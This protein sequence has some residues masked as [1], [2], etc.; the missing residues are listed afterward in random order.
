MVS[1][2]GNESGQQKTE[3]PTPRRLQEARRKGQVAKSQDL[4]GAITLLVLLLIL[5]VNRDWFIISLER[6]FITYLHSFAAHDITAQTVPYFVAQSLLMLFQ[7]LA[8]VTLVALLVVIIINLAQ[9]GFL[10]APTV[11][12]PKME[13]L[14][15]T[16][17]FKRIF[18][19]RGLV[20]F[21]KAFFII[22]VIGALCFWIIHTRIPDLLILSM[23]TP[24]RGLYVVSD[25]ML[26]VLAAAA[27]V[28]LFL[29]LLDLLYQRHAHHKQMMM[30]KQEVKDEY[31]QT[32]GDPHLKAWLRRRQR[33]ISLNNIR[34]EVPRAT[35]V[36]TN[37][38]HVAV[39]LRYVE[40][41][42]EAPKVTAKGAEYL[43]KVIR[44]LAEQHNVP[45][46][47]NREVARFLHQRVDVGQD[48]PVG[49]Y[50]AVA[51]MIAMVYRVKKQRNAG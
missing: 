10:F 23:T 6:V 15:V 36:V 38:T 28:Y 45:I 31:R 19:T 11:L 9:V 20:E 35:V 34:E 32:E 24:G 22:F 43:A 25:L 41:E 46:V 44:E 4:T 16:G 14:S 17:G 48:V 13:R 33:E 42:M 27:G 30:T 1:L 18:S 49:L 2:A 40:G 8:P 39:A 7:I 51:E 5:I 12:V 50:Q 29:A 3:Q 37:P 26:V 21:L 47:E